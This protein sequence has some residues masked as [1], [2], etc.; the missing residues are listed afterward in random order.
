MQVIFK[1]TP[2]SQEVQESVNNSS[3]SATTEAKE[4]IK[5]STVS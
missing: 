5:P 4:V 2:E 3:F 1:N